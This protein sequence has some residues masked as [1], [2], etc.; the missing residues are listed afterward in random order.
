VYG[1][2]IM[3]IS[4]YIIEPL[5]NKFYHVEDESSKRRSRVGPKSRYQGNEVMKIGASKRADTL[6]HISTGIGDKEDV[7][8][9]H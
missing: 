2:I 4:P 1:I 6:T 5:F 8:L 7:L 3:Y 9:T